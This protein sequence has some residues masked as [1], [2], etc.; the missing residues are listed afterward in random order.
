MAVKRYLSTDMT[1]E[2]HWV[3]NETRAVCGQYVG[4]PEFTVATALTT[5]AALLRETEKGCLKCADNAQGRARPR[6]KA[7]T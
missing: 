3:E 7:T 2:V 1:D 5:L 6:K 4:R